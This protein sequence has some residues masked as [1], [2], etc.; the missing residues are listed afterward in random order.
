MSHGIVVLQASTPTLFQNQ[1]LPR[2]A[3][4]FTANSGFCSPIAFLS[5]G[6]MV[7]DD[8]F[9]VTNAFCILKIPSH[10]FEEVQNFDSSYISGTDPLNLNSLSSSADFYLE[11]DSLDCFSFLSSDPHF[12]FLHYLLTL[13]LT[14]SFPYSLDP[15]NPV[16][17]ESLLPS[18]SMICMVLL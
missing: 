7:S 3:A 12:S 17:S 15:C 10:R 1:L 5:F 18:P 2:S 4:F 11:K 16:G 6:M 8:K 13:R 14:L 9:E